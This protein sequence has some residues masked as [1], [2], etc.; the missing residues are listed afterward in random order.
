MGSI[1]Q[2][3]KWKIWDLKILSNFLKVTELQSG[4]SLVMKFQASVNF[5]VG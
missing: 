5:Y 4:W 3:Y 2:F 1:I